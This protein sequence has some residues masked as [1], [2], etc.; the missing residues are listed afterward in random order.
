MGI[1]DMVQNL[2]FKI[3]LFVLKFFQH[4][5]L[6]GVHLYISNRKSDS[7][8]TGLKS[9]VCGKGV[10][11]LNK[12]LTTQVCKQFKYMKVTKLAL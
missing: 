4:K 9:H 1:N 10:A 5:T 7:A 11:M 6:N 8:A 12:S 2:H 3:S